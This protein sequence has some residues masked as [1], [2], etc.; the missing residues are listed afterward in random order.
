[1]VYDHMVAMINRMIKIRN[2]AENVAH[3]ICPWI[4]NYSHGILKII[5]NWNLEVRALAPTL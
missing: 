5:L 2:Q 1:M 3:N 4:D